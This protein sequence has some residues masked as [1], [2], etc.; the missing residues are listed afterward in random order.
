MISIERAVKSMLT[1]SDEEVAN[2][3]TL[4]KKIEHLYNVYDEISD[5]YQ[6]V[7]ESC[8]TIVRK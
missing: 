2:K 6:K 5:E 8:D 7:K 1:P 3:A 4:L